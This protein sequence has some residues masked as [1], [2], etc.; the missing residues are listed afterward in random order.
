[1]PDDRF[2]E[3]PRREGGEHA[4]ITQLIPLG[5]CERRQRDGY[6][7]CPRCLNRTIGVLAAPDRK[8]APALAG[9]A[10]VPAKP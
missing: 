5:V 4:L 3:C 6:H 1:M 8:P 7:K 9:S 2:L 10:A